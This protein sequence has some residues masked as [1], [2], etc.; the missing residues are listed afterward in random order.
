MPF[1]QLRLILLIAGLTLVS[2][3]SDSQG[4]LHAARMWHN[5][6]LVWAEVGKAALGWGIGILLYC[7]SLKYMIELRIVAPEIQTILWFGATLIGV[8]LASGRFFAWSLIDQVV[9]VG[10]LG[11]LGWLLFRVGE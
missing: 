7:F 3:F 10:V 2:G 4:F 6:D 11:G 1:D 5:G 8:A 9:A